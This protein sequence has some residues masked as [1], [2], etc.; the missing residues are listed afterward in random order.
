MLL[1]KHLAGMITENKQKK[2][3]GYATTK[4]E[5]LEILLEYNKDPLTNVDQLE[6]TFDMAF[7]KWINLVETE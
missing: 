5:G 3:I 1:L 4:K 7:Q 6:L 2:I